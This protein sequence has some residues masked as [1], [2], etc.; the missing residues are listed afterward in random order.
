MRLFILLFSI[1][2]SLNA[3]S[4]RDTLD[5]AK[6][7]FGVNLTG[8]LV[9]DKHAYN[10]LGYGFEVGGHYNFQVLDKVLLTTGLNLGYLNYGFRNDQIEE[11]SNGD[12]KSAIHVFDIEQQRYT[13]S[14]ALNFRFFYSPKI[15]LTTGLGISFSMSEKQEYTYVRSVLRDEDNNFL[16]EEVINGTTLGDFNQIKQIPRFEIGIGTQVKNANIELLLR[17]DFTSSIGLRI[18]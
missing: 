4:Q 2:F 9:K 18:R 3:F 1:L 13:L 10:Q 12:A 7:Q 6:R 11:I 5:L 14:P 16:R 8:Q 15:Y 17:R